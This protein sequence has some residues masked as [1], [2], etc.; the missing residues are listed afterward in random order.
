MSALFNFPFR[1]EN[2][3]LTEDDTHATAEDHIFR[4]MWNG[5]FNLD[6]DF[7]LQERGQF[8]RSPAECPLTQAADHAAETM[9]ETAPQ[10]WPRHS[11][12]HWRLH[13]LNWV[14]IA[15]PTFSLEQLLGNFYIRSL[16]FPQ[17]LSPTILLSWV[18]PYDALMDLCNVSLNSCNPI[19]STALPKGVNNPI[20]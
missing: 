7:A 14:Q 4:L 10:Q 3:M 12:H 20:K 17:M 13:T 1:E 6:H 2:W 19:H 9:E 16:F 18:R 5:W 15:I 8:Q 11:Q